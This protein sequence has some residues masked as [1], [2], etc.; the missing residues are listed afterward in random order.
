MRE[1]MIRLIRLYQATISPD[2]GWFKKPGYPT[3][4]YTPTCSDYTIE[5]LQI[6][7]IMAGCW[8]GL[9]RILRCHPFRPGGHDPVPELKDKIK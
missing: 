3:C 6:H 9:S 8:I 4:R 5:A 2:H 7:G 1:L